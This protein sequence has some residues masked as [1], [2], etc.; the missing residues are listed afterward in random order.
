MTKL[1][2]TLPL[3][4][5]NGGLDLSN[6][7]RSPNGY[8]AFL[9]AT[10]ELHNPGKGNMVDLQFS[11]GLL[12]RATVAADL[13]RLGTLSG[14]W[15]ATLHFRT[16]DQAELEPPLMLKRFRPL[17][18]KHEAPLAFW[19]I[20]GQITGVNLGNGC[21][22]IRVFTTRKKLESFVI[23]V[24][25]SED[26]LAQVRGNLQT[27]WSITGGLEGKTLQAQRITPIALRLPRNP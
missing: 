9:V 10:V 24:R 14:F 3:P 16:S 25:F 8:H 22:S 23:T 7:I 13:L 20:A 19:S 11:N 18:D 6:T 1:N 5:I 15:R 4:T 21:A 17:H 2:P 12:L 26:L 27:T